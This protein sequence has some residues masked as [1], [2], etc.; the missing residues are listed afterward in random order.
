MALSF[1]SF[2]KCASYL[3]WV[4]VS[5]KMKPRGRNMQSLNGLPDKGFESLSP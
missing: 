2:S 5:Q 4:N 1:S 3:F